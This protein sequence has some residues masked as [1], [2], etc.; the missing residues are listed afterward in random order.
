MAGVATD[1]AKVTTCSRD[2]QT[3]GESYQPKCKAQ[4]VIQPEDYAEDCPE[5]RLLSL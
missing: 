4:I 1:A 3:F 5:K 2:G